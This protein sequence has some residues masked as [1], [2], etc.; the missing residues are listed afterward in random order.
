MYDAPH[1]FEPLLPAPAKQEALLA[2]AHDLARSATQLAGLPVAGELRGLL[3]G[4][5]SYYTNR[6]E[7]QHTRPLEIEQALARN[8]S[9]N[10]ALAARQRLAIAHIDAE[11]AIE[12]R[13]SGESGGR[14]L[15]AAAA[16]RDIHR[17]LFSR[18][19]PEDLVTSE[20]EPV[21]AGELRQREVQVGHHVAPAHA[22]VPA[23]LERWGQFY[24]DIRRGEAAL[25][26]LA[27]AH[28]RLGWV[29]PFIDGNGRVM[30]LHTHAVLT[31]LGYTNGLWSPLRGFARSV[32]Q[33][34]ARLADADSPRRGDLDGRGNLSEQSLVAW[35]DYVLDIC[36]DQVKFMGGL[37]DISAME[38]RIAACLTFEEESQRSGI[39]REALRPLH[40]LFLTG[41]ELERGEFKTMTGLGDRT[42]V[43]ALSALI[44][45]GLLKSD[46]PQG[47]VRFALPLHALRFYFPSLWPEAEADAAS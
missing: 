24:G 15:Y 29:H 3:R 37:L 13:Y 19:P 23:L 11:A 28:Q 30:R 16:V 33:Y 1:Q 40:Y 41:G 39:R 8:F 26:A 36:L 20:S 17:E 21:V 5:N 32:D 4:M 14:Q 47:K 43:S 12:Q 38:R 27:A 42:A 7:G 44:R 46:T 35:I 45:R 34:Y 2:K 22:S 18:L 25:L 31:A 10:K 6:I 9:D